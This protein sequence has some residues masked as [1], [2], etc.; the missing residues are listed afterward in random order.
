MKL[1]RI[2][3]ILATTLLLSGGCAG[4]PAFDTSQA[5]RSVTP[6][7]VAAE[8]PAMMDREVVWG[9]MIVET[10]NLEYSTL[11]EVLAYPLD[12]NDRP[13]YDEPVTGRFIAEHRGFLDPEVYANGRLLTVMGTIARTAT[14][15]VGDSQQTYPVVDASGIYLWPREEEVSGSAVRI[16]IGVSGGF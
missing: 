12:G 8:M 13:Q 2:I 9:G 10:T 5:D 14:A 3:G 15:M 7:Q 4:G 1:N 11:I 16:G 6:A